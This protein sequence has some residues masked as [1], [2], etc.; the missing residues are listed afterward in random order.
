MYRNSASYDAGLR[1][2]DVIV[3]LNGKPV[4]DASQFR[5]MVADSKI[6][7]TAALRVMKN[8]RAVEIK[9]PIESSSSTVSRRRREGPSAGGARRALP[10]VVPRFEF[11]ESA[12]EVDGL[13]HPA[14]HHLGRLV[15]VARDADDDGF[16][17]VD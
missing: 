6:G 9:V 7:S 13:E 17:A 11:L 15:A 4:E 16:V 14:F 8:G 2:G 1:P 5:K 12:A 3:G 10:R